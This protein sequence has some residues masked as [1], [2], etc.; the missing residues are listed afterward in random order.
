[1]LSGTEALSYPGVCNRLE[2]AEPWMNSRHLNA[3]LFL[4][5]TFFKFANLSF[6]ARL[7]LRLPMMRHQQ[8]VGASAVQPKATDVKSFFS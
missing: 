6:C 2:R 8:R 1:M 7:I 4:Y 5:A 3:E